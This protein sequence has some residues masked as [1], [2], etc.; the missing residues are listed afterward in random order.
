MK[1]E[2]LPKRPLALIKAEVSPSVK[3][4]TPL[5]KGEFLPSIRKRNEHRFFA[6]DESPKKITPHNLKFRVDYV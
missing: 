5:E 3:K 1:E 6:S 4:L 2:A